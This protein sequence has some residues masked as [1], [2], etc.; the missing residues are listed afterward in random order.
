MKPELKEK[1]AMICRACG[2]EERA[3]EGYPCEVCSTF[4]CLPC[5]NRGVLRC[6]K[7][8]AKPEPR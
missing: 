1:D 8:D 7:C 2:R 3:S 5:T 6:K 4:I